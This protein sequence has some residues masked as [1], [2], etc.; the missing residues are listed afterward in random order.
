MIKRLKCPVC[1]NSSCETVLSLAYSNELFSGLFDGLNVP[2]G[3]YK[4]NY[5]IKYCPSCD[6]Y[7][8]ETSLDLEEAK[9]FY[10][11]K[12]AESSRC[13]KLS[14]YAHLAEEAMLIRLLFSDRQPAVLD[15]GMNT[16]DWALMAKAYGCK[17]YGSDIAEFS[18]QCASSKSIEFVEPDNLPENEFDFINV[19]QVFEHLQAPYHTLWYLIRSLKKGGIIKISTPGDKKFRIKIEMLKN[20]KFSFTEFKKEFDSLLP[21]IHLNLFSKKSLINLGKRVGLSVYR[22]PLKISYATMTL[23]DSMRQLN[24]NIYNPLKRTLAIGTWQFFIK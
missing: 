5:T 6:F 21:L 2:P 22:I 7:Y 17:V 24:R 19:D 12:S 13:R 8:Q 11:S 16:G 9:A 15:F 14:E 23:F 10:S 1:D 3:I 20:N 18:R 4:Q